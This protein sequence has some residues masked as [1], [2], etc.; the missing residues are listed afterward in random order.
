MEWLTGMGEKRDGEEVCLASFDHESQD[1]VRLI[2]WMRA[3]D[4]LGS[5]AM[6]TKTARKKEFVAVRLKAASLGKKQQ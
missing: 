3:N 5:E 4:R 1:I 6:W 2:T